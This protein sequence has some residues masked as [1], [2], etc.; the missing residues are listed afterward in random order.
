MLGKY[1]CSPLSGGYALTW[2]KSWTLPA[3]LCLLTDLAQ[4]VT[5]APVQLRFSS[6]TVFRLAQVTSSV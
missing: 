6:V 2:S 3:F 1:P 4:G 5:L